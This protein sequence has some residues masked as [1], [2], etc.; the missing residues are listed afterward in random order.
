MATLLSFTILYSLNRYLQSRLGKILK[1][2]GSEYGGG[3]YEQPQEQVVFVEEERRSSVL[4]CHTIPTI[5]RIRTE[6][7]TSPCV[8]GGQSLGCFFRSVND[9]NFT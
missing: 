8:D 3:L 2:S 4:E 5:N 1:N 7:R 9:F 6:T